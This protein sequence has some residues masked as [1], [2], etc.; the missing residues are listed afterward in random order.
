M[1]P[2]RCRRLPERLQKVTLLSYR[3]GDAAAAGKRVR[4]RVSENRRIRTSSRASRK[5]TRGLIPPFKSARM[6]ARASGAFPARTSRTTAPLEALA[7]YRDEFGQVGQQLA[8][9]LSM[10]V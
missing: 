3:L 2:P 10:H 4:W 1:C 7:I 6:A 5:M 8:G 9:R